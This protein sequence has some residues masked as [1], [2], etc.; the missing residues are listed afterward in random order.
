M[1]WLTIA[2]AVYGIAVAAGGIMG[3]ATAGSPMSAITGGLAGLLLIVSAVLSRSQP[4]VGF[5]LAAVVAVLLIAFFIYRYL[6]TRSP[7]PAFGVI[8]LSV[9][10]L[11]LLVVGHF[12]K[13]ETP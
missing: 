1:S 11:I 12:A 3:Y 2:V 9:L 7:M 10:M 6:Q 13:G 8:G 4:R 5:G